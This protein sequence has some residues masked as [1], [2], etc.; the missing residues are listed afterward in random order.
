MVRTDR[1]R[2]GS[3][4][5]RVSA[6]ASLVARRE[7]HIGVQ[8]PG[9]IRRVHVSEGDRVEAGAPLFEID[10]A[11]YEMA[12]RQATAGLE[13]ARAQRTQVEADLAR[14]RSLRQRNVLPQQEI[15]RL[16]TALAVARATERQAE[17]ALALA[18]HNL[19]R[20]VV[21]APYAGSVAARLAHEGTTALVQPQTIVVVLQET[22]ELEGHAAIPE[23]QLTLI[24]PGNRVLVHVEG[25]ADPIESVISAVSDTIDPATRTYLVKMPVPNSDHRLK[26]GIFA[27]VEI[28][29]EPRSDTLVAP[30][31]SIR[32][33][34]GRPRLLMVRDGVAVAVPVELGV[35]SEDTVEILRG[36]ALGD[37]VVVGDAAR[38]LA[39]GMRVS[40]ENPPEDQSS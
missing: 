9:R 31:E 4:T 25:I 39:P 11:E 37:E 16:T 40:V 23:S 10:P 14:A 30:R 27:R 8:V 15:E 20:T 24:R 28:F 2:I 3:I 36:A 7:S 17:E 29:P 26:A 1:L 6:P 13:L 34:D 22:A 32:T 19:D 33:E 35:A 12:V 18:R 5:Q 21:R 38:A